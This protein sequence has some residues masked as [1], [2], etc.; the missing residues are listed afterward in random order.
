AAG[1]AR[2]AWRFDVQTGQAIG[3]E[4]G[5]YIF[6]HSLRPASESE[7]EG[8]DRGGEAAVA[9]RVGSAAAAV[10]PPSGAASPAPSTPRPAAPVPAND[11]GSL[12]AGVTWSAALNALAGPALRRA[13]KHPRVEAPPDRPL[14]DPP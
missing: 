2:I 10:T 14:P 6:N 1:V 9:V 3:N 7:D 5:N 12:P 4:V 11:P 8:D 13:L